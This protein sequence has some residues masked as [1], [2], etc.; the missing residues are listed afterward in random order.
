VA[1]V[2][3]GVGRP[4]VDAY[5]YPLG[6]A[7]ALRRQNAVAAARRREFA[8][9]EASPDAVLATQ[10][11]HMPT[12]FWSAHWSSASGRYRDALNRA[13]RWRTARDR[14]LAAALREWPAHRPAGGR[15]QSRLL[16]L[17]SLH[18]GREAQADEC[19]TGLQRRLERW[20]QL[21]QDEAHFAYAACNLW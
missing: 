7:D 2:A 20:L 15:P 18:P 21:P 14:T 9:A 5:G 1:P 19:R 17:T 16:W 6:Q 11:G 13:R 4:P 12:L 8:H 10:M 3:T